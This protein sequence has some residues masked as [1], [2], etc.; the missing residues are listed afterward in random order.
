MWNGNQYIDPL[1]MDP[2]TYMKMNLHS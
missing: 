1:L 2:D